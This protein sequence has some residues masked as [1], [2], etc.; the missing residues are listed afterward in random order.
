MP[1]IGTARERLR[2]M[3]MESIQS[4]RGTLIATLTDKLRPIGKA[5]SSKTSK[6]PSPADIKTRRKH[7]GELY[8]NPLPST[9]PEILA[10]ADD[11]IRFIGKT[12]DVTNQWDASCGIADGK[13]SLL[14]I[15]LLI[16][17]ISRCSESI[18]D[19]VMGLFKGHYAV[20]VSYCAHNSRLCA[21]LK[22]F[23]T[24]YIISSKKALDEE[25]KVKADC[26]ADTLLLQSKIG[27]T[28]N[29]DQNTPH[30]LCFCN[31]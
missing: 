13:S 27:D 22:S 19:N 7:A 21:L 15:A 8:F 10:F 24:S 28:K 4:L 31:S 20:A 16:K 5:W 9:P 29:I 25:N 12:C 14:S 3:P 23:S 17:T 6:L 30:P 1:L 18:N 11:A 26:R 2:I